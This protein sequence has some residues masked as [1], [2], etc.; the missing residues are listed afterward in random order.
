MSKRNFLRFFVIF[1]AA[2]AGTPLGYDAERRFR[3]LDLHWVTM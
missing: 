3:V 2:L 1:V